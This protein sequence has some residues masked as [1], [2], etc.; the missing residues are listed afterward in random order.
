MPPIAHWSDGTLAERFDVGAGSVEQSLV[1]ARRRPTWTAPRPT[2]AQPGSRP[3]ALHGEQSTTAPAAVDFVS[4]DGLERATP[5]ARWC[6]AW[7]PWSPT[8]RAIRLHAPPVPTRARRSSRDLAAARRHAS[9]SWWTDPARS[10]YPAVLD[11][12]FYLH[13]QANRHRNVRLCHARRTS[14]LPQPDCTASDTALVGRRTQ[15]GETFGDDI[16][17]YAQATSEITF[18]VLPP[19]GPRRGHDV[20]PSAAHRRSLAACWRSACV[21]ERRRLPQVAATTLVPGQQL[22]SDNYCYNRESIWATTAAPSSACRWR[23][24]SNCRSPGA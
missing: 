2:R 9:W 16:L 3:K 23:P 8:K 18:G 24:T 17:A 19:P 13:G 21:P 1:L 7:R 5:P 12:E 10:T 6:C 20:G 11:P 4:H 15:Y 22:T 14:P